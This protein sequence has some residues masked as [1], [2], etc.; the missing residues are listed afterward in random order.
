M[1]NILL[2]LT[3]RYATALGVAPLLQTVQPIPGVQYLP[4]TGSAKVYV[5]GNMTFEDITLKVDADNL[6][7]ILE[8]KNTQIAK[9]GIM[10]GVFAPPPLIGWSKDKQLHITPMDGAA[11]EVVERYGDGTWMIRMQGILIDMENHDFP[12]DKMERLRKFFEAPEHVEVS[13]QMFDAMGVKNIYF[14]SFDINGV[15]GF[16]DTVVYNLMARAIK[17]VEFYLNE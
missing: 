9:G 6:N 4:Y 1:A 8:F 10:G 11:G 12:I 16:Q 2:D 3:Q 7:D 17:P 15:V 5:K 13:G 14:T